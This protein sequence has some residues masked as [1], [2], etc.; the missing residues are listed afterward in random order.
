VEAA[1]ANA[2]FSLRSALSMILN[3]AQVVKGAL[4][5]VPWVFCLAVSGLAF[6]LF[7]LQT[8]LDMH[9]VGTASAGA[10]VGFTFLGTALGTVGVALVA[11]LAWACSR[12]L[13]TGRSLEWTIRSFCLAYTPTLIF[14]AVG[15]L[16]NLAAGWNTA[17][18]FGVTGALW[19]LYPIIAICREMTSDKLWA[20]LAI[21]TVCGALVLCGWALLG[22]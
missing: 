2:S 1:G 9:R 3:P 22:I 7:F 11:A 13:G 10:A 8:G 14:C 15:L 16:F 17:I 19:A 12:P 6:T 21:S 5:R 4:D 20:S 18:A